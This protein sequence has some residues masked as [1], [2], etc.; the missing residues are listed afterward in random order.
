MEEQS[1][2][3]KP[4][5]KIKSLHKPPTKH[6]LISHTITKTHRHSILTHHCLLS[7]HLGSH[8][9][10]TPPWFLQSRITYT[11]NTYKK[12]T[13]HIYKSRKHKGPSRIVMS[14]NFNIPEKW[15]REWEC[16][17][18]NWGWWGFGVCNYMF[19][20]I[21]WNKGIWWMWM[22]NWFCCC[23]PSCLFFE[24]D[25]KAWAIRPIFRFSISGFYFKYIDFY[26]M[27]LQNFIRVYFIILK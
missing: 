7:C 10:H 1:P 17:F 5:L 12:H 26:G 25:C 6:T 23:M 4:N 27:K 19:V 3:Q 2:K 13:Q 22:K 8:W 18:D 14:I 15:R 21:V 9:N 20:C 16:D 24:C 11:H